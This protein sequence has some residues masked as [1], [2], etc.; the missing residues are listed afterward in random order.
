MAHLGS[1]PNTQ[2]VN[3]S[4]P[5][6]LRSSALG[7]WASLIGGTTISAS[8]NAAVGENTPHREVYWNIT[9]GWALYPLLAMLIAALLYAVYRRMQYWRL[10]KSSIRTDQ[11]GRRIKNVLTQGVVAHRMPRD[12]Y[13]GIYHT[14][15][16]L[17]MVGLFIVTTLVLLDEELWSPLTGTPFLRGPFYLGYSLFGDLSGLVALVGVSM[18][19]Y[20]RYLRKFR[21]VVWD[22]RPEDGLILWGL[23]LLLVNGFLVEGVRIAVTELDQHPSWAYW[24]PGG[25]VVAKAFAATGWSDT[26]LR[27]IHQ[28]FW[29]THIATVFL[30]LGLLAWTKLSHIFMA[31]TNAFFKTLEP[32]GKLGYDTDLV[33]SDDGQ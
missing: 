3:D 8:M 30:W 27:G 15:I 13:A 6:A 24:S 4:Q 18:A 21:R 7:I 32:Y 16:Y 17:G 23:L 33:S 9:G 2:P 26:T 25:F 12:I 10:G 29:W 11:I 5:P 31:P 19:L 14:M 22:Q 28:I 20:R 1:S